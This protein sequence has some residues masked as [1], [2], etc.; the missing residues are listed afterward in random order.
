MQIADG[1]A[2]ISLTP[3]AAAPRHAP[4]RVRVRGPRIVAAR[5]S[6][7][8]PA[9]PV[10]S[11]PPA[12]GP[13]GPP[14]QSSDAILSGRA[15][16]GVSGV[17][18]RGAGQSLSMALLR[19]NDR[20]S[21]PPSPASPP[22]PRRAIHGPAWL[23]GA[24]LRQATPGRDAAATACAPSHSPPNRQSF[25]ERRSELSDGTSAILRSL[26]YFLL[27]R[28]IVGAQP[29]RRCRRGLRAPAR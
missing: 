20:P 10:P 28:S 2:F 25:S 17:A 23:W 8:T 7:P 4:C 26:F 27:S 16:T 22:A 9:R 14:L 24:R 12:P 19:G 13:P 11:R 1:A 18:G 6:R 29:G 21:G 5:G 3:T 15:R